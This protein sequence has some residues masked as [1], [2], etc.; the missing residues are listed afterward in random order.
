MHLYMDDIFAETSG[1]R[2]PR[3]KRGGRVWLV[4]LLVLLAAGG[5]A[6]LYSF[7]TNY[8]PLINSIPLVAPG[9]QVT[10]NGSRFGTQAVKADLVNADGSTK[11]L[12]VVSWAPDQVVVS[13]PA[14]TKGG[15]ITV[16]AH[17]F[18]GVRSSLPRGLRDPGSRAALRAERVYRPG[19]SGGALADLPTGCAQHRR[20]PAPGRL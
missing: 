20:Q 9:G 16:T 14:Q 1:S 15:A 13:L 11:D 7:L 2:P 18:L 8:R 3:R 10:V 12:K 6:W 4:I 19:R 5:G 17:T